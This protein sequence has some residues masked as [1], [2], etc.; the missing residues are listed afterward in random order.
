VWLPRG[1]PHAA[2]T[3]DEASVHL[4]IGVMTVTWSRLLRDR[5]D[6]VA[7]GTALAA[8]VNDHT[9]DRGAAI[10]ALNAALEPGALRHAIASD[11]WRRQPQTRLRP[12]VAPRLAGDEPVIV[13]PGPLLWID[14][15]TG[16]SRRK[17]SLELGDRRLRF[18]VDCHGFIAGVLGAVGPF[19]ADD[20]GGDLDIASRRVVLERLAVEGVVARA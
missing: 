6:D 1:Y 16:P 18:P 7:S 9:A 17:H 5:I 12:R 14:D 10:A 4:T 2:E 13:T 20:V 19:R 15:R 11:V 3:V 8:V